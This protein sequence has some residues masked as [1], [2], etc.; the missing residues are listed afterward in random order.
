LIYVY[1]LDE[2]VEPKWKL[3]GHTANVCTLFMSPSSENIMMVSG[4]WDTTAR[5]WINWQCQWILQGHQ[6]AVWAAIILSDQTIVTGSA[7][8]TLRRWQNGQCIKVMYGHE[9]CVRGLAQVPNIGIVSCSNDN[10]LRLWTLD[11]D[12]L[13]VMTGHTAFVY[14]VDVLPTGE[15]ISSGEDRTVRVW[16]DGECVQ[17]MTHPCISVWTV[18]CLENGD[19][20]SGGS[21]GVVRVFSR[22]P[23]R[24]ANE[25]VLKEYEALLA[26]QAIPAQ[27]VENL[28]NVQSMDVLLAPGNKDGKVVMVNNGGTIEAHQWSAAEMRWI[29]IG[30]VV[31]EAKGQ[32][33]LYQGKEYDYLI[34]VDIGDGRPTLKLP[35]NQGEDPYDAARRFLNQNELP[36]YYL[37]QVAQF[38]MKNTGAKPTSID[39]N[40]SDPFT[41]ASRY[42]PSNTLPAPTPAPAPVST[43]TSQGIF[44]THTFLS[45]KQASVDNIRKKVLSLNASHTDKLDALEVILDA[46]VSRKAVDLVYIEQLMKLLKCWPKEDLLPGKL[47]SLVGVSCRLPCV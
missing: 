20:V 19:I 12:C 22:D 28:E 8:K 42:V 16:R 18:K 30:D 11:G 15:F 5:V 46:I 43:P 33:K 24:I 23:L 34:D 27:Q 35:Y 37:E 3:S 6:Q 39:P 1:A 4:S 25:E 29:K 38:I 26:A 47:Y 44:P 10:T 40:Y 21:D 14:S 32:K 31:G 41:G 2:H 17:T 7:D 13:R 36:M 45:F 9:D